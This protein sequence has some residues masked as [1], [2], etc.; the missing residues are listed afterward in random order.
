[1]NLTLTEKY[2][3]KANQFYTALRNRNSMTIDEAYE[4][5]KT[6]SAGQDRDGMTSEAI[7]FFIKYGLAERSQNRLI[8]ID[9]KNSKRTIAAL[10]EKLTQ[11]KKIIR[12]STQREAKK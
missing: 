5:L 9:V 4:C 3:I 12:V 6:T 2:N 1:M 11:L 7:H 8:F 10:A